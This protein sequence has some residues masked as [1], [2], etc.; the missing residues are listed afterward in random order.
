[1]SQRAGLDV[2]EAV[3]QAAQVLAGLGL[4]TAFGHVSARL[5]E[6][7]ALVT[8]PAPLAQ[9]TAEDLVRVPFGAA[10]LPEDAPPETWAHLAVYAARPG[11]G[12][13][14]RGMPP[15][16]FAAGVL[17]RGGRL[18]PQHGQGA[19]LGNVVPVH[20]D[21]R[22]VRSPAL[23]ASAAACLGAASAVVLRGNGALAVGDTPG[24]AVTRLWLLDALCRVYLDAPGGAA[25]GAGEIEAWQQA[26]PPLLERLWQHLQTATRSP[27][28]PARRQALA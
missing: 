26:A 14:A 18:V 1:M 10:E 11:V 6:V 15:A 16:S 12:A 19:W 27:A 9:V 22:W 21:A 17:A 3:A 4:V 8:P 23:A 24:A 13:V 28:H 7:S 20:D 25:L 2:A 5:D